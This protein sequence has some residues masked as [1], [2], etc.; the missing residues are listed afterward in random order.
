MKNTEISIQQIKDVLDEHCA[1]E[2]DKDF[3]IYQWLQ[4]PENRMN[5]FAK[6]S[7]RLPLIETTFELNKKL[8][9]A[10]YNDDDVWCQHYDFVHDQLESILNQLDYTKPL[11]AE[12]T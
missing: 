6:F 10:G 5:F 3:A 4:N 2:I 7:E 1:I 9:D 8:V 12:I 11:Y